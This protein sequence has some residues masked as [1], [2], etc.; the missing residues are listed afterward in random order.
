MEAKLTE[1]MT[2]KDKTIEIIKYQYEDGVLS[3]YK[4]GNWPCA[5][6]KRIALFLEEFS[7][8]ELAA[9]SASLTIIS[10]ET[11][12]KTEYKNNKFVP[13]FTYIAPNI[14]K[15]IQTSKHE[16]LLNFLKNIKRQKIDFTKLDNDF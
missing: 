9:N 13:F 12:K 10:T 2:D 4:A 6:C 7:S 14:N 1:K 8:D 15:S 3:F 5:P 11:I 16:E